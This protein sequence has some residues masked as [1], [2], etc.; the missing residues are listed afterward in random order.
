MAAEGKSDLFLGLDF[1]TQRAKA[2]IVD[3]N[4][5]R[6]ASCDV[7]FGE[8]PSLVKKFPQCSP[9]GY[10]ENEA[11]GVVTS[12][13]LMWVEAMDILFSR[14]VTSGVDFGRVVAISVSGQQ[15]GSI[16]WKEGAEHLL[17]QLDAEKGL[18]H[19]Q[20]RDAFAVPDSPIWKD[21]STGAECK[22]LEEAVG[23]AQKLAEVTGSRAYHRFTGNQIAKVSRTMPDNYKRCER[24]SL[25]SS[26]V[27][28]LLT[29]AYAPIDYSDGSGMNL[30]NVHPNGSG[31][32]PNHRSWMKEALDF[33]GED[34]GKKLGEPVAS[35]T[36]LDRSI[37]P[38]FKRYGFSAHCRIVAATGDNPSSLAGLYVRE[39]DIGISLGSSDTAFLW[40][41][42]AKP[43]VFGH[44]FVNPVDTS[45]FM[46]LLCYSNGDMTR[47]KVRDNTLEL[48]R[49]SE[50]EEAKRW[51]DF[52]RS[53]DQTPPG[54]DGNIGVFF[55][56]EEIIP[57]AK[58]VVRIDA[59]DQPVESFSSRATEIRALIE[60]QIM[61]KR[62]HA[63]RLGYCCGQG[64]RVLATGGGSKNPA[65]LQVSDQYS[66]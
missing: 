48:V 5:V 37:S 19:E 33:C 17:L 58:C 50:E 65:I 56:E 30:L 21:T 64:T 8:H 16:Y 47:K 38:Y 35:Q 42:E 41:P 53:L 52:T 39:G 46:A 59:N 12:P 13:T 22:G 10:E 55:L 57:H 14:M 43:G 7:S 44:V 62:I 66:Y 51:E 60:G 40:L 4:R 31:K 6:Q 23:G 27:C 45:A 32:A 15:C 26:F 18:L 28:C 34:L 24:I 63:E 9:N 61:A 2:I 49:L 25:V 36:V 1:S 20:L 11:T 54:N 3:R 29:G